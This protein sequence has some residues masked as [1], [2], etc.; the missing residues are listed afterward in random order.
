[1][2][3]RYLRGGSEEQPAALD[4]SLQGSRG[5]VE[6]SGEG[7]GRGAAGGRRRYTV[8]VELQLEVKRLVDM[9]NLK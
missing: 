4:E 2:H 7:Q 5:S 8:S 6:A 3:T 9:L 1:M